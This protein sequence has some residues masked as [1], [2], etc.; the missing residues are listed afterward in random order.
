MLELLVSCSCWYEEA[1]AIA[2]AE[3]TNNAGAR[4][5]GVDDGD[6]VSEFTLE[7]RLQVGM[8]EACEGAT[9]RSPTH[10]K[11]CRT[12]DR[13]QAI[14]FGWFRRTESMRKGRLYLFVSFEKTPMSLLFSYCK[15]ARA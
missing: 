7:C 12:A 3:P 5:R 1:V 8:S 15:P 14:A 6:D 13:G 10:V 11:V 4:Y 2:R 9:V